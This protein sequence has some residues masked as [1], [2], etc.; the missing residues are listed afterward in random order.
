MAP[1]GSSASAPDISN[2][3]TRQ[4]KDR[5]RLEGLLTKATTRQPLRSM[6]GAPRSQAA[7]RLPVSGGAGGEVSRSPCMRSASSGALQGSSGAVRGAGNPLP[8][9]VQKSGAYVRKLLGQDS[10][11]DG[12]LDWRLVQELDAVDGL[13]Q[14]EQGRKNL[15]AQ[16]DNLRRALNA[17]R[18][19]KGGRTSDNREEERQWGNHLR[20]DADAFFL[21]QCAKRDADREAQQ[22]FN[23]DQARYMEVNRICRQQ[24]KD[25]DLEIERQMHETS[26]AARR[27][28]IAKAQ[29]KKKR[30]MADALKIQQQRQEALEARQAKD[31]EEAKRDAELVLKQQA[32]QAAQEGQHAGKAEKIREQQEKTRARL[33]AVTGGHNAIL[34]LQKKD[35]DCAKRHAEEVAKKQSKE[36]EDRQSKSQSMAA[37][38]KK[39]VKVQ[40]EEKSDRRA[41]EREESFKLAKELQHDAQLAAEQEKKLMQERRDKAKNHASYLL[42][43]MQ[44]RS[45]VNH[46][47]FGPEQMSSVEKSMNKERFNRASNSESL[48]LL[49]RNKQLQ[50]SLAGKRK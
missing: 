5:A 14:E 42:S 47:R 34:E 17:Q 43:Q 35:E 12:P 40:L 18:H 28:E 16:R 36:L 19:E 8:D 7:G 21:E 50:Y 41:K 15:A 27:I 33:E 4:I 30:Q 20:A 11:G 1:L 38:S 29:E 32:A 39:A 10:S 9:H 22:R 31:R 13:L 48:Q 25:Q 3:D 46:G 44:D 23:A 24:E 6:G 37:E 26:V 2:R 45:T 49:V